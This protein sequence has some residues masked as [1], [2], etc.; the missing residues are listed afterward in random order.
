MYS[1]GR[2]GPGSIGEEGMLSENTEAIEALNA[3]TNITLLTVPSQGISKRYPLWCKCFNEFETLYIYI[4]NM[5]MFCHHVTSNSVQLDVGFAA[6]SQTVA[7]R[8]I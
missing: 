5:T 6:N 4:V 2:L 7:S 8:F 3:S 1:H